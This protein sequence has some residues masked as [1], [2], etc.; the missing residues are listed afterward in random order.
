M[1]TAH[2]V[3]IPQTNLFLPGQSIVTTRLAFS[4]F[5]QL[6]YT[7]TLTVVQVIVSHLT[8]EDRDVSAT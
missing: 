3:L 5:F 1:S 2:S 6:T 7:I 8:A 4:P